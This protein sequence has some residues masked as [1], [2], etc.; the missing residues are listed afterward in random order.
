MS[1]KKY[2]LGFDI[3]GTKIAACVGTDDGEIIGSIFV[4]ILFGAIALRTRSIWYTFILH[5]SLG[6]LTDLFVIWRY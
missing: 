1:G 5:A 6:I 2:I 3:G 4:G